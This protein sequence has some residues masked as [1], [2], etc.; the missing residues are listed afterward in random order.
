MVCK[1]TQVPPEIWTSLSLEAKKWLLNERK[2]KQQEDDKVKKYM[3][4]K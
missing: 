2:R 4:S 1:S 3:S